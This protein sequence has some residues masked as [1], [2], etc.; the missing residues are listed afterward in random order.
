MLCSHANEDLVCWV[1]QHPLATPLV[2]LGD[3]HD[4]IWNLYS[5]I[6]TPEQR[7]EIL[8]WYHLSENLGKVGGS[9]QRLDT[10]EAHLWRGD[11]EG[12][13]A[14]FSDWQHERV[15]RFV[16]YLT[17]HRKRI[18]NYDYCQREGMAIG[19]GAIEST[20]KQIGRRVKITGAQWKKQNVPQVLSQR[21]AYLNGTFST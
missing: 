9:K 6:A 4:D 14:Q 7:Q 20:V 2:C 16:S 12:A 18:A 1:N 8:D 19:S 11:V 10:V 13:L 15:A 5:A 17:K 3:G 21:C